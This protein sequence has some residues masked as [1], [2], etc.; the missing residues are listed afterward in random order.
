[1]MAKTYQC[2]SCSEVYTD[3]KLRQINEGDI[4]LCP[5]QGC[6]GQLKEV[7]TQAPNGDYGSGKGRSFNRQS[8]VNGVV[9]AART[10]INDLSKKQEKEFFEEVEG[11]AYD[12]DTKSATLIFGEME[13]M[14]PEQAW[15][16]VSRQGVPKPPK[17]SLLAGI[18]LPKVG[19]KKGGSGDSSTGLAKGLGVKT[20]DVKA[21]KK[22][23]SIPAWIYITA[24]AAIVIIAA[25]IFLISGK[26]EEPLSSVELPPQ[27]IESIVT[28]EAAADTAEILSEADDASEAM[29]ESTVDEGET[30]VGEESEEKQ[31]FD[32]LAWI[33]GF[34][35]KF[36]VVE[37]PLRNVIDFLSGD[38]IVVS[39]LIIKETTEKSA[40]TALWVI[41]AAIVGSC[42]WETLDRDQHAQGEAI[43]PLAFGVILTL[44]P[45]LGTTGTIQ[46]GQD[47]ITFNW[48]SWLIVLFVG[49]IVAWVYV[50]Q[51]K[52]LSSIAAYFVGLI[53]LPIIFGRAGLAGGL[54]GNGDVNQYIM[55]CLIVS[56]L[57]SFIEMLFRSDPGS[58]IVAITSV[59]IYYIARL[60]GLSWF[61]SLLIA[62]LMLTPAIMVLSGI[63]PIFKSIR[64][65]N[66]R[67]R[68]VYVPWQKGD[69]INIVVKG[70]AMC[71]KAVK[72]V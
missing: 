55:F 63:N 47:I 61:V 37:N 3:K 72:F 5:E 51:T 10:Q 39:N 66:M 69:Y 49:G 54:W 14:T 64:S 34:W 56:Q 50:L 22:S 68:E 21:E 9:S 32:L 42:I 35:P 23:W 65:V 26:N 24:A 19:K 62:S 28:Q 59:G 70:L 25:V 12:L 15:K 71:V 46:I 20:P 48:I 41:L 18:N 36:G 30:E 27:L 8:F 44:I 52:D 40:K 53:I 6:G 31:K 57:F 16:F 11:W 43:G 7:K 38:R 60:L 17:K 45:S 13:P 67:G 4:E 33:S 2:K 1:M 58:F 29:T